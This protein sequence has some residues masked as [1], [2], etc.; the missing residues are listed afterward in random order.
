MV[1]YLTCKIKHVIQRHF[2]QY[3][4]SMNEIIAIKMIVKRSL[5]NIVNDN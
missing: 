3:P 1:Y 2:S 5:S 4:E